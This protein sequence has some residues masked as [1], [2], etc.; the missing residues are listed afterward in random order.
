MNSLMAAA[1]KRVITPSDD[2]LMRIRDEDPVMKKYQ[3]VYSDLY[4]RVI[5]LDDGGRR[6]VFISCDLSA[7]PGQQRM[8]DRLCAEFGV[9]EEGCIFGSTRNHQSVT[10]SFPEE[11]KPA[12]GGVKVPSPAELEMIYMI[13]DQTADAVKEALGRLTPA[14]VAFGKTESYMNVKRDWV[15]PAGTLETQDYNQNADPTMIIM[16]VIDEEENIIGLL[17]NYG[18]AG[19]AMPINDPDFPMLNADITG[20][21]SRFVERYNG[22]KF[23]LLWTVSCVGD[24][25]CVYQSSIKYVTVTGEGELKEVRENLPAQASI[26]IV[27]KL[28]SQMALK[29]IEAAECVSDYSDH[30]D[31]FFAKGDRAIPSR[32]EYR[33][34]GEHPKKPGERPEPVTHPQFEYIPLKLRLCTVGGCAFV[35]INGESARGIGDIIKSYLEPYFKY[36]AILDMSYGFISCIPDTKVEYE[37]GHAAQASFL[38]TA[39]ETEAAVHSIMQELVKQLPIKTA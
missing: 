14:R 18:M 25:E 5:V 15:T 20:E 38:R 2:M 39:Q 7:F 30:I 9:S 36:V 24:Q 26:P 17:V 37:N 6:L 29:I 4:V 23:P 13:H 34:L 3:S 33:V 28:S 11:A 27:K 1:A 32:V 31:W 22:E 10:V 12:Y 19:R 8:A 35:S 21:I 16:K